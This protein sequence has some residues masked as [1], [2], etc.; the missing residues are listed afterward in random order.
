M[1]DFHLHF[2][3]KA[4]NATVDPSF[5]LGASSNLLVWRV[6]GQMETS[7]TP[8]LIPWATKSFLTG[9]F[10]PSRLALYMQELT[11]IE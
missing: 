8:Y 11:P 5:L 7:L 4:K 6:A 2:I 9:F 3:Y 10:C 1:Y